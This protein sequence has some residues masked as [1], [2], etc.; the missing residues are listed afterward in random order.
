[1]MK[2][3][4]SQ[5]HAK[6]KDKILKAAKAFEFYVNK[7]WPIH[8]PWV[9]KRLSKRCI[10]CAAS[11]KMIP[12]DNNNLCDSCRE[13]QVRQIQTIKDF[14]NDEKNL[15]KI[16]FNAQNQGTQQYDA[17]VLYSGG[18][19][20]SFMIRKIQMDFPGLR[21]LAISLD[22]G[23]MSPIA[24][25]NIEYLLPKLQVD[26]LFIKPDKRFYV[27]LFRYAVTHL[28]AEG[29]YGTVDFSDGEF[30][31]DTARRVAAEKEIP[32]ILCGYSRF[33]VEN[34]LKQNSFESP[35]SKEFADRKET[36]GLPLDKIFTPEEIKFWWH[37]SSWPEQK[38]ARL[39][40][41]LYCW[42]LEEEEILKKVTEWGLVLGQK[43]SPLVTNHQLIPLL[44]VLDVHQ[45]GYSSFEKEFC[46]MIREGKADKK[47]WQ[48]IFEFLEYTSRTGLFVK[49]AVLEALAEL[50]LTLEELKIKFE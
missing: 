43:Q 18:K 47:H 11:Q 40:F 5:D 46:R 16:L 45:F 30:M 37:G 22:N 19:D 10:G 6:N 17:L 50:D 42:D 39:L 20:S 7:I 9:I 32:I 1:M 29:S 36:A 8:R 12:L 35:R 3:L 15:N 41:P 27:K 23:F 21:M 14:S 44:A 24:K 38:I 49:P 34:G 4:T 33:Q 26:H 31:L 13:I 28:N 25:E 48:G 2:K